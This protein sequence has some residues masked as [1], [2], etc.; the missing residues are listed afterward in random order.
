MKWIPSFS[1]SNLVWLKIRACWDGLQCEIIYGTIWI[2]LL[3]TVTFA[4]A[5]CHPQQRGI[6]THLLLAGI[7]CSE[8]IYLTAPRIKFHSRVSHLHSAPCLDNR[9]LVQA[10]GSGI[11]K[12]QLCLQVDLIP[13]QEHFSNVKPVSKVIPSRRQGNHL[14]S[15]STSQAIDTGIIWGWARWGQKEVFTRKQS[16]SLS[17]PLHL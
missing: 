3:P 2:V 7:W 8:S 6:I 11:D 5:F 12:L 17:L 10:G 1:A 14:I 15:R 9:V 4:P 16:I 13:F